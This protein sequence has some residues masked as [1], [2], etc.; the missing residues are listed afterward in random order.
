MLPFFNF[1]CCGSRPQEEIKFQDPLIAELRMK[2]KTDKIDLSDFYDSFSSSDESPQK[3]SRRTC[4]IRNRSN[5]LIDHI[6]EASLAIIRNKKQ[7]LGAL[8]S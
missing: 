2:K 3:K 6:D 8:K 4:V 1:C 7:K 5:W